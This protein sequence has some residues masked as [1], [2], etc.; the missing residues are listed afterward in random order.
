MGMSVGFATSFKRLKYNNRWYLVT[1]FIMYNVSPQII[2]SINTCRLTP[3]T[4]T[5]AFHAN[6]SSNN[7]H[8]SPCKLQLG[9]DDW[10]E[11]RGETRSPCWAVNVNSFCRLVCCWIH[12]EAICISIIGCCICK[13]Y[14]TVQVCNSYSILHVISV[15]TSTLMKQVRI[16]R[17]QFNSLNSRSIAY[18][19]VQDHRLWK[20]IV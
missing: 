15:S 4:L 11:L 14:D 10:L 7:S 2:C 9:K 1:K 16:F 8:T 20:A 13:G 12:D 18:R 5:A 19:A 3:P 6:T 17:L